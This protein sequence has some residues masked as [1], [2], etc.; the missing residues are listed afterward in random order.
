MVIELGL[1]ELESST[2]ISKFYGPTNYE[3]KFNKTEIK[4]RV[5]ARLYLM[6]L[7]II[8][9]IHLNFPIRSRFVFKANIHRKKQWIVLRLLENKSIYQWWF[10]C[11]A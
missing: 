5:L 11:I 8:F 10:V 3:Q 4:S 9:P 2:R 1:P 7:Y 6:T